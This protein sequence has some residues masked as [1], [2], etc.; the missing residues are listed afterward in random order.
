MYP[1]LTIADGT[2]G[3]DAWVLEGYYV[4]FCL[5]FLGIMIKQKHIH[6]YC[7]FVNSVWMKSLFLI[8]CASLAYAQLNIWICWV[9]GII[10][11]VG[12]ILNFIRCCGGHEDK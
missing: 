6:E 2:F 3:I 1:I 9:V 11:T 8:F 12:A 10:M 7:A 5:F 4:F